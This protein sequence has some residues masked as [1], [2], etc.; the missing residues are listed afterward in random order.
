MKI[1][2]KI[3]MLE[4]YGCVSVVSWC[5]KKNSIFGC[6]MAMLIGIL[7]LPF[8]ILNVIVYLIHDV[9]ITR[10]MSLKTFVKLIGRD[11]M[12]YADMIEEEAS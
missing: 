8:D 11:T 3:N 4:K 5:V 1:W 10:E 12:A 6:F 9:V 2:E 7:V